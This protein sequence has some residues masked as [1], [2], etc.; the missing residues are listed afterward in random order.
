VKAAPGGSSSAI[1]GASLGIA[2]FFLLVAAV[3]AG[4]AAA[5]TDSCSNAPVRAQQGIQG[6]AN[7]RAYER[8]TPL[9]KNNGDVSGNATTRSSLDGNALEYEVLSAFGDAEGS[10]HSNQYTAHRSATGWATE[11]LNPY[12]TPNVLAP[13]FPI[14]GVVEFTSDL[15]KGILYTNHDPSDRTGNTAG[16]QI[17]LYLH[18]RGVPGFTALSPPALSP[19]FFSQG[20]KYVGSS[21]DMSRI[22]F[23]SDEQLLPEAPP[24]VTQS[25]EWHDG[26]VAVVGVLPGGE[27]APGGATL[28]QGAMPAT[29]GAPETQTAVSADGTQI[30]LTM[31]S[32]PQ[33]YLR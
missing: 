32:P 2:C 10:A 14:Q 6:L 16:D 15:T 9:D 13:V 29:G 20:P 7:C 24:F 8:V 4:G 17:R 21:T 33:L 27:V 31:G 25:Y 1:G 22:F 3:F 28:G 12:Q 23:Q 19:S 5:A 30:V 11:A 26:Q 18:E